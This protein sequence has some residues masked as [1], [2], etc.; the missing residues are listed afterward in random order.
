MNSLKFHFLNIDGNAS[1]FDTFAA[2]LSAISNE[3]S[4]IGISETNV[5]CSQDTFK[6][7]EYNSIYQDA[8]AGKK[9]SGVAL[10]I[11][12]NMNFTQLP[13][14]SHKSKDIESLFVSLRMEGHTRTVGIIYRRSIYNA[15]SSC[16]RWEVY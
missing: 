1:N 7:A 15:H 5:A 13:E 12:D 14:Y 16:H 8:I 2:T 3:F 4:V 6:L 9:G 11:R 10:Y